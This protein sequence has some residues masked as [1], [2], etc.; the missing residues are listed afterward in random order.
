MNPAL[1]IC[2]ES[3]ASQIKMKWRVLVVPLSP[4][5]Q[6]ERERGRGEGAEAL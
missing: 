1:P 4:C 2:T 5:T 6:R 3:S